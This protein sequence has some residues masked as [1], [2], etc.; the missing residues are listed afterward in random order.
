VVEDVP[1]GEGMVD[2]ATYFRLLKQYH[3]EV[4]LSLH[5]EYSLGGAE[6]GQTKIS[7]NKEVVFS[8]M[9]R[10]LKRLHEM[11]NA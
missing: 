6:H 8:A 11:W 4:P 5:F 2:F 7:V 10:D 1:L 9:R 3:I